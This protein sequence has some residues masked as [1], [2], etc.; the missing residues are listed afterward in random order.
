MRWM[1]KEFNDVRRDFKGR[2]C[3]VRIKI[4][5]KSGED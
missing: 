1:R 4:C 5:I 2:K 3:N